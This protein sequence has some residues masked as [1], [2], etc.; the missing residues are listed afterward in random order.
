MRTKAAAPARKR[1]S[2][3]KPKP[4]EASRPGLHYFVIYSVKAAAPSR[5]REGAYVCCWIDFPIQD[6]AL[7]L[8]KFYI[9]QAGYRPRT[10]QER[11]WIE[12][13]EQSPKVAKYFREAKE[14]GASFV[15]ERY[16]LGS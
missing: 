14:D 11:T 5:R 7:H 4:I 2:T 16:P 8:A 12:P 1:A 13:W 3:R 9:R 10:V 15:F 6:G